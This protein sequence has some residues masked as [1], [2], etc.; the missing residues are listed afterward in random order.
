MNAAAE[1]SRLAAHALWL[2][3]HRE[4]SHQPDAGTLQDLLDDLIEVHADET[5]QRPFELAPAGLEEATKRLDARMA[6]IKPGIFP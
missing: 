3:Y 4:I 2:V 1:R 6:V 5:G